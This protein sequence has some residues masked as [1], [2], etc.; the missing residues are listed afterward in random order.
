MKRS[1]ITSVLFWV[2]SLSAQAF[3]YPPPVSAFFYRSE[4]VSFVRVPEVH[5]DK[6][7]FVVISSLRGSP[8]VETSLSTYDSDRPT[9]TPDSEWLLASVRPYL[10]AFPDN[11]PRK[12]TVK[13][14]AL[15]IFEAEGWIAEKVTRQDGAIIVHDGV[16][17]LTHKETLLTLEE[18]K[19]LLAAH[20]Y[21]P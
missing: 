21:K 2:V 19:H 14:I 12:L 1:L 11:D 18:V 7:T 5:G 20:P 8:P 10:H 3:L 17:Q 4:T 6:V 15:G 9:F 13:I 16:D